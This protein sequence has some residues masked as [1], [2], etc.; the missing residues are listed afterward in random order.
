[1]IKKINWLKLI[2]IVL[3]YLIIIACSLISTYVLFFTGLAD[4]DDVVFHLAMIEDVYLGFLD[5]HFGLSTNH[6][7]F[8]GFALDTFGFYGPLSHHFAAILLYCF[9]W[10]GATAI[11]VYKFSIF[12][13]A[14]IGGI[15]TYYLGRKMSKNEIVGIIA[16]VAFVFMPYRIFCALCRCAFSETIAMSFIPLVF[17]GLYSIINDE[18]FSIN[19][20]ISLAVGAIVLV[21]CHPFTAI[22]TATFALIYIACNLTKLFKKRDGFNIWPFIGG[23]VLVIFMGVAFSFFNTL[24]TLGSG[25]YRVSDEYISWTNLEYVASTTKDS[26][27]FSG[28]LNL[29]WLTIAADAD[30]WMNESV[31]FIILGVIIYFISMSFV[32]ITDKGVS[33]LPKNKFYRFPLMIIAAFFL[34]L[35]TNQRLEVYL[36]ITVSLLLYFLFS[37]YS[38][39]KSTEE[40]ESDNAFPLS[41]VLFLSISLVFSFMIL[42]NPTIWYYLPSFYRQGQFAW[43]F[44]SIVSFLL[45]YLVI[46]LLKYSKPKK[47][48][49]LATSIA[50]VSLL[51]VSMG[52]LEK[53]G[54]YQ[55]NV[56]IITEVDKE[57]VTP[58]VY[59]GAQNEMVP[60]VFY[61]EEYSSEY[62]NSLFY[63]VSFAVRYGQD[64]IRTPNDYYTPAF[65]R[66]NGTIILTEMKTPTAK[67]AVTVNSES[68]FVQFPQFYQDGYYANFKG[69]KIAAQNVDSLIAFELEQGN[70]SLNISFERFKGF[71]FLTSLFYV[72]LGSM[73][74]AGIFGVWYR[75]RLYNSK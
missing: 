31:S 20:Y 22:I 43:R 13:S 32:A 11:S 73:V 61:D 17:Y 12:S 51:T 1:M 65:L 3:P 25:L 2:K 64:F 18:R 56:N 26:F 39:K 9:S 40:K 46:V 44:W 34:P 15:F 24:N 57:F 47:S 50:V 60:L 35:I 55:I 62:M 74:G 7:F 49:L 30:W 41:E 69:K 42:F 72:S 23:T 19:P 8:G 67:F 29:V 10:A 58:L 38:A 4:G 5:G 21:L 16:G 70:Y 53:R 45:T 66:G 36:A 59:S 27:L 63:R 52:N 68:A 48:I 33:R 75:K 28:L 71:T 37:F 6:Y 54:Q 14:I